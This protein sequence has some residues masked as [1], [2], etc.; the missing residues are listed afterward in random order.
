MDSWTVIP[1]L[2]IFLLQT[3]DISVSCH[4]WIDVGIVSAHCM[5]TTTILDLSLTD[6]SL[7]IIWRY[8]DP[9]IEV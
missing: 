5:A 6:M 7:R 9:I 2:L 4:G 1:N 3:V 8:M